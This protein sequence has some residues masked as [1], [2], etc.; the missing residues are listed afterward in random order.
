MTERK[1]PAQAAA[2]WYLYLRED[3]DDES[4]KNRFKEWLA[5]DPAHVRAWADMNVTASVMAEIPPSL[6]TPHSIA[7]VSILRMRRK[8]VLAGR[9]LPSCGLALVAACAAMLFMSSDMLV[10]LRAD[11][12]APVAETRDVRLADGS[13]IILAPQAAISITMNASER[14]I[15]LFQGEALFTVHHDQARPFRVTAGNAVI[16]DIGTIFDVRIEGAATVVSV[17]EGGVHVAAHHSATANRDLR[18]GEWERVSD[19]QATS[20]IVPVAMVGAWRDGTLV[21]RNETIGRLIEALRPWTST[22]IILTDRKL[23]AKRVTGTYD[24]HQTNAS[25]RQIVD[26]YGGHVSSWISWVDIVTAR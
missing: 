22:K 26:A 23:A 7:P 12:Y 19:A 21:A 10:R 15:H 11:H 25:L 14:S 3:P 9:L 18:A 6:H 1:T 13:E 4:L 24:L 20:G 5:S 8:R 2:S 16:T 17:R